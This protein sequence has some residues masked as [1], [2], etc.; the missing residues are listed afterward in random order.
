MSSLNIGV[1]VGSLSK[2]SI[3]RKLAN[4]LK[5]LASEGVGFTDISIDLPVY[6][7]DYDADYPPAGRALKAAIE[8]ADAILIVTPEYNRSI[9]GGLKNALDWASRPWGQNSLN[10]KP[11]AVVGTSPGAIGTAVGQAALR[12]VLGFL[13]VAQMNQPEVYLQFKPDLLATDGTIANPDTAKFLRGFVEGFVAFA[14]Q[15]KG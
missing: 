7:S 1:I 14:G 2:E 10:G 6:S 5:A 3:N 4:A 15:H 9:P 13:N 8:G 12:P 11:V